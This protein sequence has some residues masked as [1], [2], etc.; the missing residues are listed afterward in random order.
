MTIRI[1]IVIAMAMTATTTPYVF[2]LEKYGFKPPEEKLQDLRMAQSLV[3][4]VSSAQ[5]RL[6]KVVN[7]RLR[8]KSL[9]AAVK[10]Q[11]ISRKAPVKQGGKASF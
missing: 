1:L 7:Q 5:L 9:S 10:V 4:K 11:K 6:E 2:T 3:L 8:Q